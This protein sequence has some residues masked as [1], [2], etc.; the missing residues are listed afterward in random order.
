MY[1]AFAISDDTVLL[2]Y[3]AAGL[4]VF[5]LSSKKV[6]SQPPAAIRD[7]YRVAYD[8]ATDT[9]VLLVRPEN[10]ATRK[11]WVLVT[12]QSRGSK[13][14]EVARY[15]TT[16]SPE[17]DLNI[18]V[19]GTQGIYS[20][21]AKGAENTARWFRITAERTLDD[22]TLY[23]FPSSI[24]GLACI[25]SGGNTEFAFA[26]ESEVIAYMSDPGPGKLKESWRV[27]LNAPLRL[28]FYGHKKLLVTRWNSDTNTHDILSLHESGY[29]MLSRMKEHPFLLPDNSRFLV[30][31][32]TLAGRKL[33]L[34]DQNSIIAITENFHY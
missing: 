17:S 14:I 19:C 11:Y 31:A 9:L 1:D 5:L 33:V 20:P 23:S 10:S 30:R 6:S 28:L 32:W 25:V 16:I 15:N 34:V 24:H 7:V 4:R 3:G 8:S 21:Y 18:A 29:L 13:W 26:F 2:A 27:A 22:W 12:M